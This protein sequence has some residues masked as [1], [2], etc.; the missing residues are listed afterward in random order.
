MTRTKHWTVQQVR[1]GGEERNA[2][3]RSCLEWGIFPDGGCKVHRDFEQTIVNI[4]VAAKKGTSSSACEEDEGESECRTSL[5]PK[6]FEG[7][8]HIV[9]RDNWEILIEH[10]Y[11]AV[12]KDKFEL[13]GEGQ[14]PFMVYPCKF[15]P[16]EHW[17]VALRPQWTRHSR[18]KLDPLERF[19]YGEM[20]PEE[21]V[22][23]LAND[24][25]C[26][27][28][29]GLVFEGIVASYAMY[30]VPCP[31]CS[32]Y[33]SLRWT[34]GGTS[35]SDMECTKCHSVF[36]IKSRKNMEAIE[37]GNCWGHF[38][39]SYQGWCMLQ[40]QQRRRNISLKHFL[41]L[42]SRQPSQNLDGTQK[43]WSVHLSTID[44][45]LPNLTSFSF[46]NT[47]P[48]SIGSK[49]YSRAKS[50]VWFR[51]PYKQIDF[52]AVVGSAIKDLFPYSFYQQVYCPKNEMPHSKENK[53]KTQVDGPDHVSID[54][55]RS[56]LN[57]LSVVDDWEELAEED[58]ATAIQ[59]A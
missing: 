50:K 56:E 40:Q 51:I 37:K 15:N 46:E 2:I 33:K 26:G 29:A 23:E 44:K 19:T 18:T 14:C 17:H 12:Y 32:P 31:V 49:I 43:Y 1:T 4:V 36:E 53:E 22:Q 9:L 20:T 8:A 7:A 28:V 10:G 48:R 5:L 47:S 45:V 54:C 57:Q 55:L 3:R 16:N 41:V 30:N 58:E 38:G 25:T 21:V 39:G 35:Y 13:D 27:E 34:S 24:P 59:L 42:V 6:D 11:C 52:S